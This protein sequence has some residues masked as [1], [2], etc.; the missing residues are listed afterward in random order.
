MKLCN[1]LLYSV[2]E[3]AHEVLRSH[4]AGFMQAIIETLEMDVNDKLHFYEMRNG[5]LIILSTDEPDVNLSDESTVVVVDLLSL[6]QSSLN[7]YSFARSDSVEEKHQALKCFQAFHNTL[8]DDKTF[9]KNLAIACRHNSF[10]SGNLDHLDDEIPIFGKLENAADLARRQ[11]YGQCDHLITASK[12]FTH[13]TCNVSKKCE[14][15]SSKLFNQ[16]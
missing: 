1:L 10:I 8:E 5:K 3:V 14:L 11:Y 2:K 6:G 13:K 9:L 16:Q 12:F 7:N 15:F 4:E